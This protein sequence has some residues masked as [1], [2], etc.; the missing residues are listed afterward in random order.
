MGVKGENCARVETHAQLVNA[1]YKFT[2]LVIVKSSATKPGDFAGHK[3]TRPEGLV[4]C[5]SILQNICEL[6]KNKPCLWVA[7]PGKI[8][9]SVSYQARFDTR[10]FL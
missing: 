2:M 5:E 9:N 10:S 1:I 4:Q 7:V 6:K 8:F 3:F